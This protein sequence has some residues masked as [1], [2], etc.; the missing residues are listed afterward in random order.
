MAQLFYILA[1]TVTFFLDALMFLLLGRVLL[2]FFADEESPLL[3]FCSAVTEP[4]V[5]PM[6]GLLSRIPALEDSPIDFSFAAT[7]LVILI[8]QI[9]LPF[10]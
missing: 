2:S 3:N 10:S 9:A 8:V 4:V 5:A 6:R 1:T 7:S